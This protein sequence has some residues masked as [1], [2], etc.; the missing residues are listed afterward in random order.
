ML[1]PLGHSIYVCCTWYSNF[2]PNLSIFT[3]MLWPAHT[4]HTQWT[5]N[6]MHTGNET[7]SPT[8]H[9]YATCNPPLLQIYQWQQ[10]V[11]RTLHVSYQQI[12]VLCLMDAFHLLS[13][14]L[15][16]LCPSCAVTQ[17]DIT[18]RLGDLF[19]LKCGSLWKFNKYVKL[20]GLKGSSDAVK[21]T[22]VTGTMSHLFDLKCSFLGKSIHYIMYKDVI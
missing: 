17:I 20:N 7:K 4:H 10:M 8:S 6:F 2:H 21:Q 1:V 3:T 19:N 12:E 15:T 16:L 18:G 11:L 14:A 9:I 13:S 5:S 22:D